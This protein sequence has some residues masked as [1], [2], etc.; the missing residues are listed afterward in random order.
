V[1]LTGTDSSGAALLKAPQTRALLSFGFL[2]YSQY[3]DLRP[4]KIAR[5]MPVPPVLATLEPDFFPELLGQIEV[6]TKGSPAFA[7]QLKASSSE[8]DRFV[9]TLSGGAMLSGG[10]TVA[11]QP[12]H[13][14]DGDILNFLVFA[15]VVVI[16]YISK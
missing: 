12:T 16:I 7:N 1:D 15:V 9:A 6:K 10:A 4:P 3:Q 13:P 11:A 14:T 2:A 8:L 5:S